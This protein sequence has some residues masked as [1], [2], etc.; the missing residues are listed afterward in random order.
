MM[1]ASI[2]IKSKYVTNLKL[3][4]A[5]E[6]PQAKSKYFQGKPYFLSSDLIL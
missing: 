4:V 2:L 6:R 3:K 5:V 1:G